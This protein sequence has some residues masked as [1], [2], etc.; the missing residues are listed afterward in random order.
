MN[1]NFFLLYSN[2]IPVKGHSESLIMDLQRQ[3]Y[4][5]ISN[6]VYDILSFDLR[7]NN[8]QTIMEKF[9]HVE[10]II[11]YF[12]YLVGIEY[13]FYTDEPEKFPEIDKSFYTPFTILTSIINYDETSDYSLDKTIKKFAEIDVQALQL[14]IYN[15]ID[16]FYLKNCLN[17]L[18]TSR[19][20][21]IE[22][23]LKDFDYDLDIL[24]EILNSD[25]RTTII[26]HSYNKKK[27]IKPASEFDSLL[28]TTDVS[29]SKIP[30]EI[31]SKT[32]FTNNVF[33]YTESINYNASLN[34]KLCVDFNGSI[35]NYVSHSQ[36]F[37]NIKDEVELMNIINNE[38]FNKVWRSSV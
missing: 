26:L 32:L 14:R 15:N 24:Y 8:L 31:F 29:L 30:A 23:I 18:K 7:E 38:D 21:T 20:R 6:I 27:Q 11:E 12:D 25:Y 22:I 1:K 33:M 9:T 36:Y 10:D 35:K 37:G 2:C 16:L 19:N 13:G 28:Y 5:P 4:L 17:P 3:S 34:R